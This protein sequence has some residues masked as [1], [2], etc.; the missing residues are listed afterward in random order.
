MC[1]KIKARTDW[2]TI[3]TVAVVL[4]GVQRVRQDYGGAQRTQQ[5]D[6]EE[7][8]RKEEFRFR[9]REKRK[10]KEEGIQIQLVVVVLSW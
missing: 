9:S 7:G 2:T 4:S 1:E 6:S 8:Q 3:W 10:K 5:A